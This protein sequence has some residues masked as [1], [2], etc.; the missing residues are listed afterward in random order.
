[1]PDNCIDMIAIP[2]LFNKKFFIPDFQRGYR[3]EAQ[4][5]TDLLADIWEFADKK[6]DGFY[7]LQP[8]VV[9]KCTANMKQE[10]NLDVDSDWYEVIDGQQRLT[11]IR[12]LLYFHYHYAFGDDPDDLH[13]LFT[14]KYQT[15]ANSENFVPSDS[16]D[17]IETGDVDRFHMSTAYQ[18]MIKWFRGEG[19]KEYESRPKKRD[20]HFWD[21]VTAEK[22]EKKSIQFIWYEINEETNSENLF[23]RLNKGKI[24]LTNAELIKAMFLNSSSFAESDES[25]R[26]S[27]Q[28][29]IAKQWDIMEHRLND[30]KFWSFVSNA[31]IDSY[32]TKIEFLFEN[33]NLPI[34]N[35]DDRLATYLKFNAE[36]C[37]D[38]SSL[39]GLWEKVE[40]CYLALNYWYE[41][42]DLYH[43]I[44]FLIAKKEKIS[45][46]VSLMQNL[47]KKE[48]L[49]EVDERIRK[50]LAHD[51]IASLRYDVPGEKKK[52][53]TLLFFYNVET[54]R[55]SQNPYDFYPFMQHKEK[56]WTL[57]HIHA[58]QSEGFN[59]NDKSAWLA[60]LLD[61]GKVLDDLATKYD[62]NLDIYKRLKSITHEISSYLQ[63]G[64][65]ELNFS[66]FRGIVDNVLAMCK[67]I[68][69]EAPD[70]ASQPPALHEL[71]NMALLGGMENTKLTN[72]IFEV[73]RREIVKMDREGD[74]IPIC[75]R[76]VFLKYY[77]NETGKESQNEVV[78]YFFWSSQDR[79]KYLADIV[80]VLG[81]YL[82]AIKKLNNGKEVSA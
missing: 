32:A 34:E 79:E 73:K 6:P 37:R 26:I 4:Q 2:D 22:T 55:L 31:P 44:G 56:G 71:S 18:T 3:W 48:F 29:E 30:K 47:T 50:K 51:D 24:P 10:N 42:K 43:K 39:W 1:M 78:H 68:T 27:H 80:R 75:T 36:Y 49:D 5:V 60:W 59:E 16:E 62:E 61:H 23:E 82:P 38:R 12:I 46:L 20:S 45:E 74:F 19:K 58:Q 15:R 7:C 9:K 53:Q 67:I 76:R 28:S 14:I 57:E 52:L 63:P 11:T 13:T 41:N 66:L 8:I 72:S 25:F 54:C 33:I 40:D 35:P 65:R 21:V 69:N 17:E 70:G 81:P 77:S 64:G